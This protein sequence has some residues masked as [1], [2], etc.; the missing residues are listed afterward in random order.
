MSL[1]G[2]DVID[3]VLMD[4]PGAESRDGEL[5]ELVLQSHVLSIQDRTVSVNRFS[6]NAVGA[7]AI[8]RGRVT[9]IIA[10]RMLI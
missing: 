2:E 6:M 5:S 4:K 7:V 3:H 9:I 8:P 1:I 10:I